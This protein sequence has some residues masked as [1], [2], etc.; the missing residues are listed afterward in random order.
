MGH[1][2]Q[3]I[4]AAFYLS[5]V[6]ASSDD[7]IVSKNLDGIITSWNDGAER[8]F[9]YTA[10]EV[11]GRSISILI[12]PD[13]GDEEARILE[14]IRSGQRVD[15]FQTVRRR[16]DGSYIDVSLTVSPIKDA[17]GRIIGA[18]KIARDISA[19]V[20]DRELLRRSEELFRV[21][22]SSIGDAVIA[23]DAEGR[24]TFMNSVAES[25]TGWATHDAIGSPLDACFAIVNELN[26]RPA[27]SPV[28]KVLRT[29]A[30]AGLANHTSLVSKDGSR[31]P[32]DDSAAPIRS[33]GGDVIGVV[34]VFRDVTE[35]RRAEDT[36]QESEE[37]LR[38][39][40]DNIAQFAWM[41]DEKGSVYWYNKRWYDYTG[42][43]LEDVKGWGWKS[44]QHPDHVD[45][46]VARLQT[47]WDS[48]E[49]WEDIFPL[50]GKD[51]TYRWF[52][53]RALPVRDSSGRV[54][55]WLGTNTDVSEQRAAEEALRR[56]ALHDTLTDLP[57]RAYF[58]ERVAQA[59]ARS[60]RDHRYRFAVLLLDC[61]GFKTIN[62][63]LGHA[64]GDRVLTEIATRLQTCV[65]P[66]D[67]VARLGGDEFTVLLEEIGGVVDVE[68]TARRI[69]ETLAAPLLLNDREIATT[70]SIGAALSEPGHQEPQ[71]LLRDA[72]IAMYH[73][74]QQGR[75]R[76]QLFDLALRDSARARSDMEADLRNALERKEFRL[77][78]QPI[79][80]LQSGRIRG[81]EALLRWRRPNGTVVTP[82]D[83]VALAE[84]T[85]LTIPIGQ[86]VLRE[87]GR[88]ARAWMDQSAGAACPRISVN[89]SA[90]QLAHPDIVDDVRS[91]IEDAGIA[92]SCLVFDVPERALLENAD[93]SKEVLRRLRDTG[94]G[95]H[96]DDFAT[97]YSLL[98]DLP[99]FPLDGIKVDRTLIRHIGVR[100]TDLEIV[101]SIVDVARNLELDVIAEGVETVAQRERLIAFGCE[102]GQGRLIARPLEPKAAARFLA[103]SEQ[104]GRRSA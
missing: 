67:V 83:F 82:L 17:S 40:A 93:E 80:E 76:F 13:R 73:A 79:V 3:A 46:V 102:L 33:S 10:E 60:R 12:P 28:A 89:L 77:L 32:I 61:D 24:V 88:Y 5:A 39:L 87:V 52:L 4:D 37:Q 21:T 98:Q 97:A 86:W 96:L 92:P 22:L 44:L 70:A 56:G 78:F 7:A 95:L 91:A 101:R 19:Q 18:S 104:S 30:V 49:P 41:A 53:S 66:G 57:N 47:S 75:A 36:L 25:L 23:T 14:L 26:G 2:H 45:R 81:L 90:K 20:R 58:L 100:R 16:K 103:R 54:V 74:K 94:V 35:R 9:G 43:T 72:D 6:I 34:L 8:V 65:R 69:Q 84:Q 64:A 31:H 42:T 51:G 99:L 15:H 55:R 71:D 27:E 29:G 11:T 85:G 50:R 63:T 59:L 62:D 68:H 48:G 38:T 1:V